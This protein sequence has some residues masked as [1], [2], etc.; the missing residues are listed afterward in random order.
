MK[1]ENIIEEVKVDEIIGIDGQPLPEKKKVKGAGAFWLLGMS[2]G[3]ILGALFGN[4]GLGFFIGWLTGFA[5]D[6]SLKERK[7]EENK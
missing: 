4:M 6:E 2:T 7:N 1:N 5:F 3:T